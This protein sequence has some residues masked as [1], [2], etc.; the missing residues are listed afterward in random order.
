MKESLKKIIFY[1]TFSAL[2]AF[3]AEVISTNLPIALANPAIYLAYGLLYVFFIDAMMRWNAKKFAIWYLFGAIVGFITETYVAKVTFYGAGSDT[4]RVLGVAPGAILFIILFYHAFFSF[5]GPAYLATRVLGMPLPVSPRKWMD[6]IYIIIPII[7][8]PAVS[9]QLIERNLSAD[10]LMKQMGIS[11][12]ILTVWVVLLRFV[13]DIK[14]VLL[15]KRERKGLFVVLLVVYTLF[16]FTITNEAHGHAPL[17]FPL[18]PMLVVTS[19][20]V[21]LL[22]LL[23]KMLAKGNKPLESLPY[24]GRQIRLMLFIA[25][26]GWHL[27]VTAT[28]LRFQNAM[29]PLLQIGLGLFGIGGVLLGVLSF[30]AALLT[31]FKVLKPKLVQNR[32]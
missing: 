29:M 1:V 31:M 19:F 8:L 15:S 9:M 21:G 30:V 27:F 32:L 4:V 22:I 14:N 6:L 28:L 25:W 26:L 2:G 11:A 13:G 12:L 5:I 3:W 20:I 18:I 10:L 17:D 24:S 16:L 23:F 7:I